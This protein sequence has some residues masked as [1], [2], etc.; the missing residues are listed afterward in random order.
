MTGVNALSGLDNPFSGS[1]TI[2]RRQTPAQ[3]T[4]ITPLPPVDAMRARPH[5]YAEGFPD[6]RSTWQDH[7]A[8]DRVE[9]S[10]AAL[11]K[12]PRVSLTPT[13]QTSAHPL[14]AGA[15]LDLYA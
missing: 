8:L 12:L 6:G 3:A 2:V 15:R 14:A 4:P 5:G 9:L 13:G 7:T 11:R 10:P 1:L